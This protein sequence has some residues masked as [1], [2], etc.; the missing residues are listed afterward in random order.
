MD[1][2]KL[3][4][5]PEGRIYA[6]RKD[7][8]L[9]QEEFGKRI[10][11]SRSAVCNYENG[12]RPVGEQIILAVCREFGVNETWMRYGAGEPYKHPKDGVID[13]LIDEYHCTKFEGDFL[14]TYFQMDIDERREFVKCIYRLIVPLVK[15][16]EGKNPYANYFDVTN[17]DE[18]KM[19]EI[20]REVAQFRK[21]LVQ[22]RFPPRPQEMSREEIHTELD[23]QLDEEKEAAENASG[24]GHGKSGMAT[25]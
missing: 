7:Q 4:N 25:G 2:G 19:D 24:Y 13:R 6:I 1:Y 23:R 8:N 16:M 18:E 22:E 3:G 20:N 15:N 21:Q 17:A 11:V 12:T 5:I 9:N 10:G 14:K